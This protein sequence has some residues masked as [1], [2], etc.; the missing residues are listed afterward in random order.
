MG[1]ASTSGDT[2]GHL[3]SVP[4]PAAAAPLF[5]P[6]AAPDMTPVESSSPAHSSSTQ[7]T[8]LLRVTRY[9]SGWGGKIIGLTSLRKSGQ[10]RPHNEQ[11]RLGYDRLGY[12]RLF[13]SRRLGVLNMGDSVQITLHFYY[14]C[15]AVV[16]VEYSILVML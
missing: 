8:M 15:D 2:I 5:P 1:E 7:V 12:D 10:F 4:P 11:L 14:F 6:A 13:A 16:E 3:P 9:C